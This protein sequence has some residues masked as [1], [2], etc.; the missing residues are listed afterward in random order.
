[1]TLS[2]TGCCHSSFCKAS[3]RYCLSERHNNC[4]NYPP[5][6]V[7][8][9]SPNPFC[10]DQLYRRSPLI[11][12]NSFMCK[13]SLNNP[14]LPHSQNHLQDCQGG[15]AHGFPQHNGKEYINPELIL[16]LNHIRSILQTAVTI[17]A[18]HQ[19]QKHFEY[20]QNVSANLPHIFGSAVIFSID[21]PSVTPEQICQTIKTF[22]N[23][24]PDFYTNTFTADSPYP[25]MSNSQI[26]VLFVN[27]TEIQNVAPNN[28]V[29][30]QIVMKNIPSNME[31]K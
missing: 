13:G 18:G 8:L 7:P 5:S 12:Q 23:S 31:I 3:R 20:S 1:M 21:K 29:L 22:Y 16:L 25:N 15:E 28:K 2:L 6:H 11:T 4:T 24:S 26:S 14:S 9:R 30:V 10:D 19:C 17:I 27:D